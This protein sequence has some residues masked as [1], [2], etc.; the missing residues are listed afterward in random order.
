MVALKFRMR[1]FDGALPGR[2]THA[3]IA[4][5]RWVDN[6]GAPVKEISF[7][8]VVIRT[9]SRFGTNSGMYGSWPG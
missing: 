9:A 6:P 5:A 8:T 1:V 4:P 2:A 3:G 7:T